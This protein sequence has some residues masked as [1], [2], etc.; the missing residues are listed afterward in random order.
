MPTLTISVP[1]R[2]VA[3]VNGRGRPAR[4]LEPGRHL[5]RSGSWHQLVDLR[6][7]ALP[8]AVQEVLTSDLLSVKVSAVTHW[9]VVDPVAFVEVSTDPV[10]SIYLATQVGLR[11][12]LSGM[13]VTDLGH[14]A[15]EERA[16]SLT[17]SVDDAARLVGV[18][19]TEV[20]VKD[21]ILPV[22]VRSA[23]TELVTTR[24]RAAVQLEAARAETAALRSLAN[25]ARLLDA[26]PALERLRLVQAVPEGA[27]LTMHITADGAVATESPSAG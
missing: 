9:R 1:A 27:H 26:H 15:F 14:R 19:V 16:S 12:I 23:A 24:A 11:D 5:R 25:A 17:R 3:V 8:L 10:A 6:L 13:T 4:V 7:Q 18:S 2:H 22:D 21:V 20:V